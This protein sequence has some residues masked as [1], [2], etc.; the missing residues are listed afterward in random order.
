MVPNGIG[1]QGMREMKHMSL[2]S[3][4]VWLG[5]LKYSTKKIIP[6]FALSHLVISFP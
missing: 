5:P 6:G 2:E 1:W 3:R 4:M